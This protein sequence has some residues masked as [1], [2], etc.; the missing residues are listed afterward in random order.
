MALF[1]SSGGLDTLL[2]CIFWDNNSDYQIHNEGGN[3]IIN[4][5][6]IQEGENGISNSSVVTYG[7]ENIETDPLFVN[8]SVENYALQSASPCIDAGDPS[9]SRS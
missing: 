8:P 7:T 1:R 4:Y 2:N 9:Y 5:C 3:V 6:D